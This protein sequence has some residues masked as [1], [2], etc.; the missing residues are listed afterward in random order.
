MSVRDHGAEKEETSPQ[1]RDRP[2][3]IACFVGRCYIRRSRVDLGSREFG[4]G[5]N[6]PPHETPIRQLRRFS[7]VPEKT[8]IIKDMGVV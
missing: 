3:R 2:D 7:F 6:A 8:C 5:A 1:G 4:G